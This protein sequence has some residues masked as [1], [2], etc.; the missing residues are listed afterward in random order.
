MIL[1]VGKEIL[2]VAF[3]GESSF[4]SQHYSAEN[5]TQSG[6]LAKRTTDA[7]I[8]LSLLE[9]PVHLASANTHG[10]RLRNACRTRRTKPR[11]SR[12]DLCRSTGKE[13]RVRSSQTR[14]LLL[15]REGIHAMRLDLVL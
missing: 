1:P 7:R 6:I 15:S 12:M 11:K 9:A 14:A 5:S 3:W 2:L 10:S 4:A 13:L 8:M